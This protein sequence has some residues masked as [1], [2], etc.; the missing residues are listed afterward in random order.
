MVMQS[1]NSFTKKELAA[2]VWFDKNTMFVQN[3][4]SG[5]RHSF[6]FHGDRWFLHGD[7]LQWKPVLNFAGLH[8]MWRI[9]GVGEQFYN[10]DCCDTFF[11]TVAKPQRAIWSFLNKN[12]FRIPG[13]NAVYGNRVLQLPTEGTV[14]LVYVTTSGFSISRGN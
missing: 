5:E 11:P 12:D 4:K 3:A 2:K 8:T 1:W 10:I 9:Y 7:I 13:V 6:E 14:F